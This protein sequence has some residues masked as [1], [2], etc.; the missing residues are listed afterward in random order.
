MKKEADPAS[1]SFLSCRWL[2]C[3]GDVE[4]YLGGFLHAFY[5]DVFQLAVEVQAAGKDVRARKATETQHCAV[6]AASDRLDLRLDERTG[7]TI[8]FDDS[9]IEDKD[10]SFE[11]D[12]RM[13]EMGV[14]TPAEM[15]EKWREKQSSK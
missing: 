9:I 11:R 2:S 5:G 7:I 12:L 15:R 13:L 10:T 3:L 8:D 6:C 1:F 14:I 4:D